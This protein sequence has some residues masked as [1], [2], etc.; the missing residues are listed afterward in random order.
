MGLRKINA[1]LLS[2]S[3]GEHVDE[4][5][6]VAAFRELNGAA[7]ECIE[8]VVFADAYVKARVVLGAALTFEDVAGFA[9]L[10]TEDFYTESFAF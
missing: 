2:F 4:L 9:G 5:A 8:S 1:S 3:G 6:T 10:T 7:Y